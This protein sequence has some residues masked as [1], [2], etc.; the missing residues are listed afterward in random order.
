MINPARSKPTRTRVSFEYG[1]AERM[2][3]YLG[4]NVCHAGIA[5]ANAA[6]PS[7]IVLRMGVREIS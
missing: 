6:D 1:E 4:A 3:E 5:S 7:E 2:E